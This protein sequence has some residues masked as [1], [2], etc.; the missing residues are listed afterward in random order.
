LSEFVRP[1]LS[2]VTNGRDKH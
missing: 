1:V 2:K